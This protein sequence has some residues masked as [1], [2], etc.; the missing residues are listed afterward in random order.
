VIRRLLA[1]NKGIG[2][3]HIIGDGFPGWQKAGY[4]TESGPEAGFQ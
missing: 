1:L 3:M 2:P 4:P